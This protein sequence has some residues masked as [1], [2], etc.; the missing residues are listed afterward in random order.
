LAAAEEG[1]CWPLKKSRE[2]E[3][4]G[5]EIVKFGDTVVIACGRGKAKASRCAYCTRPHSKLCDFVKARHEVTGAPVTCD[6]KLCGQCAVSVGPELDHCRAHQLRGD[7]E[8][9]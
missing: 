9:A 8:A 3:L 6:A 2:E 7:K 4:M 1:E 5:C